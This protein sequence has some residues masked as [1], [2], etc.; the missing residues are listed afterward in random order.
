MIVLSSISRTY[1]AK[2]SYPM[3]SMTSLTTDINHFCRVYEWHTTLSSGVIDFLRGDAEVDINY[4]GYM[5]D[6]TK[7]KRHKLLTLVYILTPK[8][9]KHAEDINL[10][11][12]LRRI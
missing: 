4:R 11:Y 8:T 7:N 6:V 10:F 5:R 3:H 12:P 2:S 9:N 1:V